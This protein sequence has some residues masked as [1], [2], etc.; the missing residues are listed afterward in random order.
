MKKFSLNQQWMHPQILPTAI[1]ILGM[2]FATA[3]TWW[4]NQNEKN[5]LENE[6]Q[7]RAE[8]VA[9]EIQQRFAIPIYGL[10]SIKSLFG[11]NQHLS[12]VEFRNAIAT[13]EL[14]KEYPGAR[15]FGFVEKVTKTNW[16]HYL[17]EQKRLDGPDFILQEFGVNDTDSRFV[18]KYFET[19]FRNHFV[20]GTDF[21]SDKRRRIAIEDAINSGLPSM[22]PLIYAPPKTEKKA[23]VL[24]FVA[25]YK[26]DAPITTPKERQSAVLGLAYAPILL[27]ELLAGIP[28]I[29]N[30]TIQF[31][32]ANTQSYSGG[33]ITKFFS[34]NAKLADQT[35]STSEQNLQ[36]GMFQSHRLINLQR[37]EF[38][39][40]ISSTSS[41]EANLHRTIP[42]AFFLAMTLISVL[43]TSLLKIQ[44]GFSEQIQKKLDAAERDNE[45]LLS[46]LNMH[47]IVSV[48]DASGCIVDVNDA[49]CRISGYPREALIGQN[50]RII[51]SKEQSSE[52]WEDVWHNISG[53]TPWRGEVCNRA[54]N[55]T[56]FWVDTFIAP[57]KNRQGVIEKYIAIC[58]DVTD[59]K[60]AAQR[61]QGAMRES[62]AL[63]ST[64]NMH[65]IVSIAN[66]AGK[67][68]DVNQAYC[69][70]SGFTREEI[71]DGNHK[72]V[73]TG[74]QSPDFLSNM[75]RT[76]S[77]GTPWR[78]EVCNRSKNGNLYWVDT[79]I[80]PF[81][82]AEG[83]IEKFIS[84]RTDITASKKAA[85][86]LANQRS[87]LAHIIEGTNVGT[88]EWNVETGEMRLNERWADQI[89][90]ELNELGTPTIS[91]WDELTHPD[92]L[93]KAKKLM[94]S[95]FT[96][97]LT[98]YECEN[99]LKHKNGHWIWVLT[100]GRVSS[101][102]PLG[103]P[104]WVSGTQMDITERK[105]AEAELQK[106]TQLLLAVRDQLTKA[107]EVAELG[108]WSW[109][110]RTNALT[111]NERMF[112]IYEIPL[113]LRTQTITYEYWRSTLHP[114]DVDETEDRLKAAIAGTHAYSP[115]F[116]II[117]PN[118]GIRYIQAA[119]SVERDEN[120]QAI[121]LTGINRDITLQYQAEEALRKAKQAA[122]DASQAKSAFLANMSH[123]IRTPMNAIL[124][125]LSLL[126]KTPLSPQQNDYASKT[127]GA[128]R[129]LLNL[130]NDILDIS[131]VEAGKM[132]LD[133]H[134]FRLEQ[135]LVDLSDLLSIN[136]A[137]K[138]VDILF[139]IDPT[140][141]GQLVGDALRLRQVLTN[142][143][144]NAVKFTEQG[145]VIIAIK[146]VS[147]NE[148]RVTLHFSVSDTGIGI[149]P[150]NQ[151]KIFTG[152]TQAETSTT[153]RYGGSGLGIAISQGLVEMMGGTLELESALG[154]GSCFYFTIEL[155]IANE[156]QLRLEED[157]HPHSTA[158][159]LVAEANIFVREHL[160]SACAELHLTAEFVDSTQ[161][162]LQ[163]LQSNSTPYQS[164]LIDWDSIE[165]D[166]WS[167][168]RDIREIASQR[169]QRLV[170]LMRETEHTLL[171]RASPKEQ[172]L[173]DQI[174]TKPI[175][176]NKL[177]SAL[178]ANSDKQSFDQRSNQPL[179][180][181]R[182]LLVED[183]IN[184]QQVARELLTAEGA[185]ITIA[186]HGLE[187]VEC[188]AGE[189]HPFDLVLMDLQMP[190]M[191]GF[192]ATRKIRGE[193]ARSNLPII[194]MSANVM[195]TDKAACIEAGLNDHIGKP[196]DL[197]DLIRVILRHTKNEDQLTHWTDKSGNE[198]DAKIDPELVDT[199]AQLGIELRPALNRLGGKQ[200]LYQRM[201][202]MFRKDL[203][204]IP[205]QLLAS[206]PDKLHQSLRHL[207]TMKGLAGTLGAHL[208]AK[209]LAEIEKNLTLA[210]QNH[211]V[212]KA[213]ELIQATCHLIT[214]LDRQLGVLSQYLRQ[215]EST[216]VS[217]RAKSASAD[218]FDPI[219]YRNQLIELS[220]QLDNADMAATETILRM[221]QEFGTHK[222]EQLDPIAD[223]IAN[224]DFSTAQQL[225]THF[226]EK[227]SK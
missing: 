193:L 135:L 37:H 78:G 148:H 187:A 222:Q 61:L 46:T 92:D 158:Y 44:L 28:D 60:L 201:L 161:A 13:H 138:P 48:T 51:S 155:P 176:A 204:L 94:Q 190:V 139:D 115:I 77:S 64:L 166:G 52:F 203:E 107:A 134:P 43:L 30:G 7:N 105:K 198:D 97:D 113:E 142:L 171:Q 153:R 25:T 168:V 32:L 112:D 124:G 181:L 169:C 130:L 216:T 29:D 103:K 16:D 101:Y 99:R 210:A 95:H 223:A 209:S 132:S 9:T 225:C 5:K 87:A 175:N 122:D 56:I 194:A 180:H 8:R 217:K 196:F 218:T 42:M 128:A 96:H 185:T 18:A 47:A 67:I 35:E 114:D 219:F 116:R 85:S 75:W 174:L 150:E 224:L 84:I 211:D 102:T 10:N 11:V 91:T 143:G 106:S 93:Q 192:T 120:N 80:A 31:E 145:E 76:I 121:L 36:I 63:L 154:R 129:S 188:I 110:L 55:G 24:L 118:K 220:E 98:Y 81:K 186:N 137:N 26:R 4:L 207:H 160:K 119:G 73:A 109:D 15:G 215:F 189:R 167:V 65:A 62:D 159:L 165:L 151:A 3:G 163:I 33:E 2:C 53:G 144:S 57:F 50:H 197:Q 70:I 125:M 141:P 6:F 34:S 39:L 117:N 200:D 127:E 79:F 54:R 170:L 72:I 49:F 68:I 1:F 23:S 71:L 226:L 147:K 82:N 208:Q 69:R 14:D 195:A 184:N 100:R 156:H 212:E 213:R 182:I 58:T 202:D 126:R 19:P 17:A 38:K 178:L 191:D 162:V 157:H 149:A 214:E 152:F 66:S 221:Q 172:M 133:P 206:L 21:A 12:R 177:G 86:R 27:P 164:I 89:G 179:R 90:Y 104:E 140:I 173:F 59:S 88:W 74:V 183:N 83:Q 123:E 136:I 205:A 40:L 41:F 108:I 45:A 111:F 131:K 22:S 227:T 199:A 146:A 20:P